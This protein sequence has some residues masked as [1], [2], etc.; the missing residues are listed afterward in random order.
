MLKRGFLCALAACLVLAG[1]APARA[2]QVESVD[3]GLISKAAND[4]PIFV[5]ESLGYFK[6][7][8]INPNYVVVGSAAGTAQQLAA[9][10]LGIA[11]MA[12]TT[13]V[14]AV[15]GGAP[16]TYALNQIVTPPYSLMAKKEIRTL[17]QLKGKTIIIGGAT[18]ATLI[19]TEAL[20]KT[21][22]LK[23]NDYTFTYA[24]STNARYAALVSGGVDAAILFPPIDFHAMADGYTTLGNVQSVLPNF[25]FS[26][27]AVNSAWAQAHSSLVVAFFKSYLRGLRWLYNPANKAQALQILA[28]ATNTSLDDGAKSYDEF[29]LTLKAFSQDGRTHSADFARVVGALAQL[30]Q[31]EPPLPSP[32]KF[33]DNRYIDR[34]NAELAAEH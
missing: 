2:Q 34:A 26:G 12:S 9:G 3:I 17:A 10:S 4:W 30:K 29:F 1:V 13:L 20:L 21:V 33:F 5:A 24:G 19:F 25:P 22:G 11:G 32:T 15:V 23:P 7:Y 28:Q 16:I 31:I 6:R 8:G 14:Q 27:Y 18:D